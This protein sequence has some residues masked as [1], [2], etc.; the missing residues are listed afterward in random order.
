MGEWKVINGKS[1]FCDNI[2]LI[3]GP[4]EKKQHPNQQCGTD[5]YVDVIDLRTGER[6]SVKIYINKSGK[7]IKKNGTF[8]L[9]EFKFDTEIVMF[10][11]ARA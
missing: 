1:D 7:H 6:G 4:Y 2:A 5:E 11:H 3:A 9:H 8:Y 10:Q